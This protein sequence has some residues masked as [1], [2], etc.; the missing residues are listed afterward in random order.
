MDYIR[1][2][3]SFE[4]SPWPSKIWTLISL[5]CLDLAENLDITNNNFTFIFHFHMSS[6]S[7]FFMRIF[8][9]ASWGKHFWRIW[10]LVCQSA[11][12]ILSINLN[13]YKNFGHSFSVTVVLYF[14]IFVE[15]PSLHK[16]CDL[17]EFKGN[18][19]F[20]LEV[21]EWGKEDNTWWDLLRF[22]ICPKLNKK[23]FIKHNGL[24]T[25]AVKK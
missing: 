25:I 8:K 1:I 21:C 19:T 16:W 15:G 7:S 12:L 3:Q 11:S 14:F 13:L 17:E 24:N 22:V 20:L 2:L 23:N 4:L 10:C 9:K 6:W 5:L 18:F